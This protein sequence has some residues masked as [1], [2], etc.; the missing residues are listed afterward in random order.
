MRHQ[1]Q[2]HHMLFMH[3]HSHVLVFLTVELSLDWTSNEQSRNL[4]DQVCDLFKHV[5]MVLKQFNNVQETLNNVHSQR[6]R[7]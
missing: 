1:L 2:H 4:F 5:F 3:V 6:F 7:A